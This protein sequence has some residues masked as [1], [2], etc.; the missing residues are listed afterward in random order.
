[1]KRQIKGQWSPANEEQAESRLQRSNMHKHTCQGCGK[2]W[3]HDRVESYDENTDCR[4]F[5]HML[6]PTCSSPKIAI[7]FG[8]KRYEFKNWD[9]ARKKGFYPG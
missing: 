5:V 6:C 7:I 1:M 4:W 3:N 2:G 8:G 9:E